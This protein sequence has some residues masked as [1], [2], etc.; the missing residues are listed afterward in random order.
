M[1]FWNGKYR[2]QPDLAERGITLPD[3]S[4]SVVI[5]DDT[6]EKLDDEM[7]QNI[8]CVDFSKI[9]WDDYEELEINEEI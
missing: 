6:G 5:N 4:P 1:R 3:N 8:N 2:L 9:E 7:L